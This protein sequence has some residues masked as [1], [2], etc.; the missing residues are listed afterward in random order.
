VLRNLSTRMALQITLVIFLV[1]SV[2]G[3]L[4]F[5]RVSDTVEAN[6]ELRFAETVR[7]GAAH[8][9]S[10]QLAAEESVLSAAT[11]LAGAP[12]FIERFGRGD[13]AGVAEHARR[14]RFAIATALPPDAL[15]ILYD[16]RGRAV[17]VPGEQPPPPAIVAE[18]LRGNPGHGER[19]QDGNLVFSGAAPVRGPAGRIAGAVEVVAPVNAEFVH[20]IAILTGAEI[21]IV[22]ITGQHV[23]SDDGA[24]PTMEELS[25]NPDAAN[26]PVD[27][28]IGGERYLS[29]VL[30]LRGTDG[31]SL[32]LMYVGVE[33]DEIVMEQRAAQREVL[34]ATA[35]VLA[36]GLVIA[37]GLGVLFTRPV[38]ALVRSARRIQENDLQSP[39]PRVGPRE[40]RQLGAAMDEMRVAILEARENLVGANTQLA[41][42]AEV[43][44]AGLA[45]V[46]Q[47]L[48][49]VHGVT[50]GLGGSAAEAMQVA[51]EQ[52][53]RLDWVDAACVL[54]RRPTGELY[55]NAE[56]GMRAGADVALAAV[57]RRNFATVGTDGVYIE[58]ADVRGPVQE[59]VPHGIRA[60][61]LLPLTASR[62][63]GLLA[64]CAERAT[65]FTPGHRSLLDAVRV[66][67]AT[68]LDRFELAHEVEESRRLGESVLREMQDGAIVVDTM[69]RCITCNAAAGRL[70]GVDHAAVAGRLLH[71]WMPLPDTTVERLLRAAN[72]S[73][74]DAPAI[75]FEQDGR[76]LAFSAG[77]LS[78][79]DGRRRGVILLV[80]DV[81]ETVAAERLKQ[82]FVS[83]V[84]HEL[85][86][87]LTLIRTSIDLLTEQGAGDLTPT[88]R[89][90]TEVLHSNSDRLLRLINDLLDMSALDSGRM[91][92]HQLPVDI[93]ALIDEVLPN[94]EHE[95]ENREVTLTVE[96]PPTPVSA[97]IDRARV[98]QVLAN[99]I[100]N[101]MKYTPSGGHIWLRVL[102]GEPTVLVQVQDNGIGIL[103]GEQPLLFQKFQRTRA[104]ERQSGG[105]GLGL[106]IARSIVELHGGNIWCESDGRS[107]STFS[108]TIPSYHPDREPA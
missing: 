86:T 20:D 12:E 64:V 96:V 106:A 42:R 37:V 91:R 103:P 65:E 22:S 46:T 29:M 58:N 80:R 36:I 41:A 81:T 100:D 50:T 55:P 94:Y 21:S 14:A 9:Q 54:L 61:V 67:L 26:R 76:L 92:L 62:D 57:L 68:A 78:E 8:A 1:V 53:T 33:Y 84:G 108:F 24:P 38:T 98:G 101:A 10:H 82:D 25:A 23:H 72:D 88:Q 59:L 69:A 48:A 16:V 4:T 11:I 60:L 83:M 90:I 75:V 35:I 13:L 34:T 28:T 2:S 30:P 39:V 99:L 6:T 97:W 95:A 40:L 66:E 56:H 85:R 45:A 43:S 19:L 18:A 89:R 17:A 79:P 49:V 63:H 15:L 73:Q 71:E 104:G 107:G 27:L 52:L 74:E 51:T 31:T 87:P 102:P 70:L 93:R 77:P 5:I 32:G 105:T 47:E 44:A 7:R 3:V